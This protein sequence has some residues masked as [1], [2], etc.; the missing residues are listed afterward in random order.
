MAPA[1]PTRSAN[2]HE[3][4]GRPLRTGLSSSLR[5][6][7]RTA[8]NQ[9]RST[10]MG[11]YSTYRIRSSQLKHNRSQIR[12]S[13]IRSIGVRRSRIRCSQIRWSRIRSSWGDGVV[14]APPTAPSAPPISAPVAAPRPPPA[15]PPMAAPV[16]AP[17]RPPP[18]ARWP[19]SYGSVQADRPTANPTANA[20]DEINSLPVP[21]PPHGC[22]TSNKPNLSRT[23]SCSGEPLRKLSSEVP[24]A[25]RETRCRNGL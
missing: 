3:R 15:M 20:Q 7:L 25:S 24:P 12:C 1:H 17:N 16:P 23:T 14:A 9:S 2:S 18:I 10:R 4:C 5:H 11:R 21:F 22:P 19:G 8:V 13:Q 6:Q